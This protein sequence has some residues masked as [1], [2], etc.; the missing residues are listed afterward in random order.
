M[1]IVFYISLSD[2]GSSGNIIHQSYGYTD[3]QDNSY[4][5]IL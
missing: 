2:K 4:E 5:F 3:L 1:E